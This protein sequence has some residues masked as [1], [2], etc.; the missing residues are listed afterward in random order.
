MV[1]MQALTKFR[2][3]E[4]VGDIFE[5]LDVVLAGDKEVLQVAG[6]KDERRLKEVDELLFVKMAMRYLHKNNIRVFLLAET[7][8]DLQKL[9][10]Y[11]KEDYSNIQV[12]EVAAM[13]TKGESDDMLLNL[14]NGSE[15]ICILSVLPSPLEEQFV[16]RNRTLVNAQ[17]WL[18]LG[19]LLNEMKKSKTRF[20]KIKRFVMRLLLKK[21]MTKKGENA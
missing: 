2:S 21:E 11:M 12:V 15:S 9:E 10:E 20:E 18:G 1:T 4:N 14:I 17:L 5:A 3:E 16:C 7:E 13:E 19:N 8:T 6:I